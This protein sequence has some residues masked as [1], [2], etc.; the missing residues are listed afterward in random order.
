MTSNFA[1]PSAVVAISLI[2]CVTDLRTR[3]IPNTLTFG[4]AVAGLVAHAVLE[5]PAGA[6]TAVAG[7]VTGL[8]VFLPFFAL[9]GMGGGDVKLLAGLGAWLGAYETL[10]LALYSAAAGGALAVIVAFARGYLR[11]AFSNVVE[12]FR[13]W[14]QSGIGPVPNFTLDTPNRPRLAYALPIFLG[15][16]VTLWR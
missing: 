16:V 7:W 12:M 10:Y 11:T 3:R 9:G 4:A 6:S 13:Y 8:L 1:I 15:V 2:A 5:G 14:R